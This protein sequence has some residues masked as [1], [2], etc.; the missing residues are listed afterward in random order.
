MTS[1]TP[2]KTTNKSSAEVRKRPVRMVLDNKGYHVSSWY[3]NGK[4]FAGHSTINNALWSISYFVDPYSSWH[5][6]S[7][8][9]FN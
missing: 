1:K 9:N 7:N 4:E 8:E 3:D 2:S 5:R 6:G